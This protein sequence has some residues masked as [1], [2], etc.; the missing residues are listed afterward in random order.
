MKTQVEI[1]FYL[2]P[3]EKKEFQALLITN[4]FSFV[5]ACWSPPKFAALMG[6][7]L[8]V[9]ICLLS[10]KFWTQFV[11]SIPTGHTWLLSQKQ[12]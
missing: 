6:K 5:I 1:Y 12:G 9:W 11:N 10:T 2:Q 4:V 7:Q 3:I 8:L